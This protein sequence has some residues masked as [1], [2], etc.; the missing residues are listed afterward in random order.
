MYNYYPLTQSSKINLYPVELV[1]IN[2]FR[3]EEQDLG[4]V[5][6]EILKTSFDNWNK[7]LGGRISFALYLTGLEESSQQI[8]FNNDGLMSKFASLKTTKD[9][10]EFSKKYG[11]LGIRNPDSEQVN[12]QSPLARAT[13]HPSWL[14]NNYGF[15]V[16]E[17]IELWKWHINEIRKI[18]RLYHAVK[19]AN[20]DEQLYEIV[21]I[22][23]DSGMFGSLA[24]DRTI[25]TRYFV[26]W[27]DGEKI[28][29]LPEE[30][31]ERS[32]LQIAQYTLAKVLESHITEGI[33]LGVGHLITKPSTKG[34]MITEERYS[35]Y[36]LAAIYYD[37]WQ[38]IN[39]SK[40]VYICENKN[41]RLPFVRSGRRKHCNDSCK[42]EAY[43]IRLEENEGEDN[44]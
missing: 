31:E 40:N 5:S 34:F 35:K 8:V 15:S 28:L 12:S 39:N 32:I 37:L 13:L 7:A 6:K 24:E 23:M 21:E 27:T 2:H 17:P 19:K 11:L 25:T 20:S 29:L 42:Q 9:I 33:N 16:F 22:K 1:E 41:C 3:V 43:R 44:V 18:L 36:L 10:E 4:P 14:F 30:F 26:Y 38:T